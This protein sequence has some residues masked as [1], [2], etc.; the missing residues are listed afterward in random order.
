MSGR[1]AISGGPRWVKGGCVRGRVVGIEAD[2]SC[3]G[4][5]MAKE[6]LYWHRP[7]TTVTSGG[8]EHGDVQWL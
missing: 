3:P 2:A 7:F 1:T 5:Q 6:N 8:F 4:G